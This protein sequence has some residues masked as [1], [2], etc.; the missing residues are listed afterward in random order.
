[1]FLRNLFLKTLRDLRGQV[2]GWGLGL[3]AMGLLVV[4]LYPPFKDQLG[5]LVKLLSSYPP[6]LSAFFGDMSQ[7]ARWEG[8]LNIEFYSWIPPILAI[9]AIGTGTGLIAGEE[10]KGTLDLLLSHPIRRWRVVAEKFAA[11]VVATILICGL[12]ALCL[13]IGAVMIGETQALDGMVLAS[14]D[15]GLLTITGG[16]FSLMASVIFRRRLW[17]SATAIV[18][19]I[20]SW[21]VESLGK[22]VEVMEPYRPFTLFHYY[23]GGAVL[24]E[25]VNWSNVAVL[26][27]LTI[28]FFAI[29]LVAF[30][31]RDLAV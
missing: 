23:T 2:W 30:Q 16:A 12:A 8:W 9:F 20:G 10:E 1:M 21:F 26:V 3:G 5:D 18:V 15:M 22:V 13:V 25:G 28:L 31:Q 24:T 14:L 19:V 17:A 6:A 11:F 7:L 29:S 4:V 27:G